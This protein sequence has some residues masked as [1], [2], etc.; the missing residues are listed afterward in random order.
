MYIY[1]YIYMYI[2]IY[3]CMYI[4]IYIY[5]SNKV[6]IQKPPVRAEAL[7]NRC[8]FVLL[9]PHEHLSNLA[10]RLRLS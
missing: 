2:Y 10:D 7:V 9:V 6:V 3:V 8:F 1:I 5:M 4:Y